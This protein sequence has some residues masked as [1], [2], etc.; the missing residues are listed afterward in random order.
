[1][2]LNHP[3][4]SMHNTDGRFGWHPF[5]HVIIGDSSKPALQLQHHTASLGEKTWLWMMSSSWP[6]GFITISSLI[7][8]SSHM[9]HTSANILRNSK[10]SCFRR[11]AQNPSSTAPAV[12]LI[13]SEVAV[14]L[15][16]SAS[17][18]N[19]SEDVFLVSFY[20]SLCLNMV[21]LAA[22]APSKP[23]PQ[24]STDCNGLPAAAWF[25]PK[26]A[27]DPAVQN[28]TVSQSDF[29][30]A[31]VAQAANCLL[32][33]LHTKAPEVQDHHKQLVQSLL[34]CH[35]KENR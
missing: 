22:E 21:V 10:L 34:P 27:I 9:T 7:T 29:E 23:W 3:H 16:K 5:L 35:S 31:K 4:A 33:H 13:C 8:W 24:K 2:L 26:S 28:I 11:T 19:Y 15:R 32:A 20:S 6:H 12:W 14:Q 1:M 17:F 30:T 25:Q 18:L